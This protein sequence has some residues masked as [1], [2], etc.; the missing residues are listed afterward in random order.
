VKTVRARG[1]RSQRLPKCVVHK[2]RASSRLSDLLEQIRIRRNADKNL[3][4]Q[5]DPEYIGVYD[6]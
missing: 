6:E 4:D 2:E 5:Q 3:E 1:G